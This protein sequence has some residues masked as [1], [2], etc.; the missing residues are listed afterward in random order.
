MTLVWVFAHDA[1]NSTYNTEKCRSLCEG[2]KAGNVTFLY[3]HEKGTS[4]AD[5]HNA[6]IFPNCYRQ[7]RR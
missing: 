2:A 4:P 3:Q 5:D 7:K 1:A 6:N